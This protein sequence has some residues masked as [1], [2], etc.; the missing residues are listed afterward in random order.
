M[1]DKRHV[2]RS[3]QAH[4]RGLHPSLQ[5]D[6]AR[7][8]PDGRIYHII[9]MGQGVSPSFGL[10]LM[11]SYAS[12]IAPADRWSIVNYVRALQK[13]KHPTPADIDAA[14]KAEGG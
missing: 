5:S 2:E 10:P 14:K 13:S 4:R 6:K 12:Q 1:A 8:Y 7:A 3:D 11:P 9:T